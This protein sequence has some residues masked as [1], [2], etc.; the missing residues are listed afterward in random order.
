MDGVLWDFGDPAPEA[1]TG[2][3][4]GGFK[5]IVAKQSIEV[6]RLTIL[7]GPNSSGKSGFMQPLLLL[8]QTLDAPYDPGPLRLDGENVK[9]TSGDQVL[10]RISGRTVSDEFEVDISADLDRGTS[11]EFSRERDRGFK[12]K[13]NVSWS[14]GNRAVLRPEM[15]GDELSA[16]FFPGDSTAS[17]R[18]IVADR[19]FLRVETRAQNSSS[20]YAPGFRFAHL[21]SG[22]IH[23]PGLRGSR[24]RAYPST[25]VGPTF[26]GPFDPYVASLIDLWQS[27][28]SAGRLARLNECLRRIGLTRSI[29]AKRI[30]DGPVELH[31]DRLPSTSI[32]AADFV[33]I[34]DVGFGVSTVL[35]VLVAVLTAKPW[36]AVYME[37]PELHLHP[38]AQVRLA[39]VLADAAKRGVRVIAETHSSLLI[40]GIQTLV[41]KGELDPS[42]V[43]LHWFTRSQKDGATTVTSA[44]LDEKGAF[45]DWP[46]DFDEVELRSEG[47]YLDAVGFGSRK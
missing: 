4:V 28:D 46:T 41:A 1:I 35:P 14:G 22:L 26:P 42:L 40:R 34:A 10:S 16:A 33:N 37:Q 44:N 2:L 3:T 11:V 30:S 27:E 13:E 6:R 7:A 20:A 29:R 39:D 12:I 15:S 21:I 38:R 17:E 45:G 36:Q 43:K 23:I 19:C 24:E 31:V 47:E 25:G 18:R 5:S 9:F 32:S 8:K